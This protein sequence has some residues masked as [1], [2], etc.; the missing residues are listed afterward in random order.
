MQ[1]LVHHQYYYWCQILNTFPLNT[2]DENDGEAYLITKCI[3]KNQSPWQQY[4][5]QILEETMWYSLAQSGIAIFLPSEFYL[6]QSALHCLLMAK[7]SFNGQF[8]REDSAWVQIK[9]HGENQAVLSPKKEKKKKKTKS[10]LISIAG[11]MT[12][13]TKVLLHRKKMPACQMKSSKFPDE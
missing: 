8:L 7:H 2:K 6:Q 12:V 11:L 10:N 1:Y 9:A 4:Q 13:Y 3:L 5:T